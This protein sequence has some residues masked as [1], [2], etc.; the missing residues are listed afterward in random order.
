MPETKYRQG[1]T[2]CQEE[3][4]QARWVAWEGDVACNLAVVDVAVMGFPDGWGIEERDE[5]VCAGMDG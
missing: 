3:M 5:V 1:G 2:R 4:E